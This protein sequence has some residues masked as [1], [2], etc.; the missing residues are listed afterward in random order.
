MHGGDFSQRCYGKMAKTQ[1]SS[2]YPGKVARPA[3]ASLTALSPRNTAA[4]RQV[5][6]RATTN[7]FFTHPALNPPCP[8]SWGRQCHLPYPLPLLHPPPRASCPPAHLSSV[9]PLSLQQCRPAQQ[10]PTL[11]CQEWTLTG[12]LSCCSQ[13]RHCSGAGMKGQAASHSPPLPPSSAAAAWRATW[14]PAAGSSTPLPLPLQTSHK[15]SAASSFWWTWPLSGL[16][17]WSS[18][19]NSW[20]PEGESDRRRRGG[21]RDWLCVSTME[22]LWIHWLVCTLE[23]TNPHESL[24]ISIF[25]IPIKSMRIDLLKKKTVSRCLGCKLFIH[26]IYMRMYL[27]VYLICTQGPKM[28]SEKCCLS[29]VFPLYCISF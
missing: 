23:R 11:L 1:T 29:Y 2:P 17:K 14:V 8:L 6:R 22:L 7:V 4:L 3:T 20:S 21:N 18:K 16:L 25:G 19:P 28:L 13:H 9:T 5:Q 26:F 27:H 12:Q 24:I 10:P 15:T